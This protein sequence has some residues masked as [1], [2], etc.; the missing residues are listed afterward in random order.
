MIEWLTRCASIPREQIVASVQV[1]RV[2]ADCGFERFWEDVTGFPPTQFR[3]PYF[4]PTPHQIKRN[5]S[6]MGCCCLVVHSSDLFWRLRAWQEELVRYLGIS[7]P[8]HLVDGAT[9]GRAEAPDHARRTELGPGD[10]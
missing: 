4:K 3:A 1:H 6:Y 2:Y 5:Q 9:D 8:S 7:L 10:P